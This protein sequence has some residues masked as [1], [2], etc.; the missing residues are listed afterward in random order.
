MTTIV[1]SYTGY[2]SQDIVLGSSNMVDVSLQE[3]VLL[4]ET[5][6]SALGVSRNKSAVPYADQ[7]VNNEEL[8]TVTNKSVLNALQGKTA[9]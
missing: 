1:V 9:G 5:V 6:I 4:Q 8:N 2:T 7:T 3:G